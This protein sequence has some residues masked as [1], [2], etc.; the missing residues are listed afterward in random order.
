[1]QVFF[2]IDRIVSGSKTLVCAMVMVTIAACSGDDDVTVT[3]QPVPDS[4]AFERAQN[5]QTA[6]TQQPAGEHAHALNE[7]E[8]DKQRAVQQ[9]EGTDEVDYQ[10]ASDEQSDWTEQDSYKQVSLISSDDGYV[11][12]QAPQDVAYSRAEVEVV[13]PNGQRIKR[14]YAPGETMMLDEALPDGLYQ[15]ESVIT[16]E[17]DPYALEE[18]QAIR[19]RGDSSAEAEAMSRHRAQGSIPSR[20]D[21]RDNRQS[22]SFKVQDGVVSPTLVDSVEEEG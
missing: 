14:S 21:A 19:Q 18:L 3:K 20:Q 4:S 8:L 22:G 2:N 1:M 17:I 5:A 9:G 12:W 15:W 13:T 11:E 7:H 16:P 6:S 10:Q